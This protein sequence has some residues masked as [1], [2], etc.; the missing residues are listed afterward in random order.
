[1]V[2][3]AKVTNA[4]ISST[5]MKWAVGGWSFFI[6]E[7]FVIS[8]NRSWIIEKLGDE[9]YHMMFGTISTAAMASTAYGY[10]KIKGSA[11]FFSPTMMTG[12]MRTVSFLSFSIG[13]GLIS[14]TFPK[15]QTPVER[16][17]GERNTFQTEAPAGSST[18]KVRCPFDF[19]DKS[20]DTNGPRGVERI[21]RHPSLWGFGFIC[22]GSAA[23]T[24]SIP[25]ATCLSMPMMVALLGGAH[26]DSR[27]RRGMGGSLTPEL[28]SSTS[29]IPF[30]AIFKKSISG[31]FNQFKELAE[32]S[33]GLNY[34]MAFSLAAALAFRRR[35]P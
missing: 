7:N 23:R 27:Y 20:L 26:I 1:M 8:E 6:A 21:S 10:Y 25:Q 33:K 18:W 17:F 30:L 11:P 35:V 28:D 13:L 31:N 22:L 19:T 3:P 4:L 5:N 15:L 12:P 32:E 9:G 2:T 14:Q 29:N 16:E 34:M 24:S